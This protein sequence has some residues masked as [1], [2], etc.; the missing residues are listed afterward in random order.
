MDYRDIIT[1][2]PGKRSG[3]PC[4]RGLRMTVTDVLEYLA[5]GVTVEEILEDFPDLTLRRHPGPPGLCRR[6]RASTLRVTPAGM[7]I[8]VGMVTSARPWRRGQ[9]HPRRHGHADVTMPPGRP[10]RSESIR[11]PTLDPP[12]PRSRHRRAKANPPAKR[13]YVVTLL[14]GGVPAIGAKVVEE[15]A[16]VVEAADEAGEEGR[17]HLVREVADLLFHTLVLL[18]RRDIPLAEVEAEL[19][20]RFGIGGIEEKELRG[21]TPPGSRPG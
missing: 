20:R 14:E 17:R 3:K 9:G 8:G 10:I 7:R 2:E 12:R 21:V 18:G 15:A 6:P 1:I 16:E 5:S 11:C 4:I 13:S 19:A